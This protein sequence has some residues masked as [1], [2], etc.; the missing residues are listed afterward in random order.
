MYLNTSTGY[1]YRCTL[2]GNAS[3]AK[4]AYAGSIKGAT[5]AQGATGQ[6]GAKGDKGD[7]GVNATTTAVFST[8]ANG[9]VPKATNTSGFL[10]GDGTWAMP[11][12]RC[13]VGQNTGTNTKPWYK[14]GSC[15]IVNTFTDTNITFLVN[16][17][18][19]D[20]DSVVGILK[21]HFRT[22][23]SIGVC[24]QA[25]LVWISG[26]ENIILNDF[27]LAYKETSGTDVTFEL[28]VNIPTAYKYY[29]FT[30]LEESGRIGFYD[31][32]TLHSASSAGQAASITSGYTQ[33]PSSFLKLGNPV[34]SADSANAV[35]WNNVSGKPSSLKNPYPLT[36]KAIDEV[37]YDGSAA[38][39]LDISNYFLKVVGDKLYGP[40]TMAAD[41][42]SS[43]D[44]YKIEFAD[45]SDSG[46][47]EAFIYRAGDT[48]QITAPAL[49][50][51]GADGL[52]SPNDYVVQINSDKE[53]VLGRSS[54]AMHQIH[55]GTVNFDATGL[56]KTIAFP[57][58]FST[59]P[60]VVLSSSRIN[61]SGAY[62]YIS[63]I[64]TTNFTIKV[65]SYGAYDDQFEQQGK[66]Y[67]IAIA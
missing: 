43:L 24:E 21:C 20:A 35:A 27:V 53:I 58:K 8:S 6:Q 30:V 55:F 37:T 17:T 3:V 45:N 61:Y 42:G 40:L 41:P 12:R 14:F 48:L 13:I 38:K 18:F 50:H 7:A 49:L 23:S 39:T 25:H 2:A 34:K 11:I 9:L 36:L 15:K 63:D 19:F 59:I 66:I 22:A 5:G 56:A 1:V 32:W 29:T 60:T 44:S 64:T 57:T 46:G 33:I 4:W 54:S 51:L 65:T 16:S 62:A 10:K 67:Y 28:W 26:G 52:S 47:N 31:Y